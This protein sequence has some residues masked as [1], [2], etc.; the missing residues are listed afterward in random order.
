MG[1]TWLVADRCDGSTLTRVRSGKVRVR[2]FVKHKTV[3]VRK[4]HSYVAKP[5]R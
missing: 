1:T 5:R 2:D 3:T 4:G